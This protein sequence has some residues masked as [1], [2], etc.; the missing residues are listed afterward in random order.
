MPIDTRDSVEPQGTKPATDSE[1]TGTG[2]LGSRS[3][4]STSPR[5]HPL[6]IAVA[7]TV[8]VT[9]AS[10]A[11]PPDYAATAVGGVFLGVVTWLVLRHDAARIR[12]FGLSL[13]GLLEPT[14]ID[15]RR[16]TREA[17]HAAAWAFA[18]AAVVAVPFVIGFR[19]YWQPR[20]P[21]VFRLPASILDDVFGQVLVIALPEEAFYRGYLLTALDDAWGTP[22]TLAKAKFGWG[23]IASSAIFA[24]GHFLTEPDPQRLAVFF[25]ALVFGWLRART[26]GVGAPALFHV[27]C[28]LLASTL[29]RGYAFGM[30]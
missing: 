17:L 22:W 8:A 20:Q 11:A 1:S 27:L 2:P 23:L 26:G 14:A 25:P 16:V 19:I 15:W 9:A 28:N 12:H 24:V 18:L 30:S 13:G 3:P 6:A 29:S 4:A 5:T 10:Y 21:F 7:V